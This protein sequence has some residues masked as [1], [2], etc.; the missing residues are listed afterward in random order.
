MVEL[1]ENVFIFDYFKDNCKKNRYRDCGQLKP[2]DMPKDKNVY[3]FVSHGHCDHYDKEVFTLN[4]D[5][6]NYIF[7]KEIKAKDENKYIYYMDAYETL[8]IGNIS[9]KTYGST[10]E[11]VSFLVSAESRTIFHAGDLNWWHWA[12][13]TAQEKE[14]AKKIFFS[15]IEKITERNI[16]VVFFPVDP[17]LEQGYYMGGEVFIE[18][19][20]PKVFIPMH[21]QDTYTVTDKFKKYMSGRY[22]TEILT[23][24]ER[25]EVVYKG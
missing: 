7:Y 8:D 12:G 25:G 22:E 23:I 14:Y 21:F 6:V 5:N 2:E 3:I 9:I 11:G 19:I 10:D 20:Q 24:R 1:D 13:E 16:D 4:A 18:K 17:R 15:E